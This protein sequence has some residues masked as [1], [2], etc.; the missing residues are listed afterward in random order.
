[1]A[2]IEGYWLEPPPLACSG[3]SELFQNF[4]A[5]CRTPRRFALQNRGFKLLSE[6]KEK[7]PDQK[8]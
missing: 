4:A 7:A 6:D 3:K 1:M 5:L 2:G 8:I